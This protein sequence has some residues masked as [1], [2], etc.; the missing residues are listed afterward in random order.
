MFNRFLRIS[1]GVAA[2]AFATLA[3]SAVV[4]ATTPP[5]QDHAWTVALST[6]AGGSHPDI[7]S[8]LTM[9]TDG[10]GIGGPADECGAMVPA[11]PFF[12]HFAIKYFGVQQNGALPI[13]SRVA[14]VTMDVETN[15]GVMQGAGPN[16]GQPAKCGSVT[17]VAPTAFDLW[18]AT[19]TGTV[20]SMAPAGAG[21]GFSFDQLDDPTQANAGI[22]QGDGWPTGIREVPAVVPAFATL[23]GLPNAAI[24]SRGYGILSVVPGADQITVTVL[25]VAGGGNPGNLDPI[26]STVLFND[27]FAYGNALTNNN[28]TICTPFS[29]QLAQHGVSV[30]SAG[31]TS[32]NGTALTGPLDYSPLAPAG[33][34]DITLCSACTPPSREI[35]ALLSTVNDDDGDGVPDGED[36]CPTVDN[37]STNPRPHGDA[38][39]SFA[40]IGVACSAGQ[41]YDNVSAAAVAA[42]AACSTGGNAAVCTD[43]DGDGV[44]NAVDNCPFTAN[45]TQANVDV[46][47]R[48]DA[49]ETGPTITTKG[50]G[51][52]PY[53]PD[54]DDRC[55]APY[56]LG[57]ATSLSTTCLSFGSTDSPPGPSITMVDSSDDGFPDSCCPG[58]SFD[59]RNHKADA[60]GDGYSNADEGT[61]KDCPLTGVAWAANAVSMTDSRQAWVFNQFV[62]DVVT[63]GGSTAT[64]T[65][66]TGTV[67][68][69]S[70]WAPLGPAK[71]AYSISLG[72]CAATITLGTAET[73][74]C[75]DAGRHCGC[76]LVCFPLRNARGVPDL[77]D[78]GPEGCWVLVDT[79]TALKTTNLGKSD[80][81]LDGV[82]S[83]LDL[84]KAASWIG[85]PVGNNTDP[86]WEANM[87][88]DGSI[89]ILDLS[90]IAANFGRS[91]NLDCKVE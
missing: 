13:A 66:N 4:Q 62:G 29:M 17:H 44:L 60:N 52:A 37:T 75:L 3:S 91:V 48:G 8:A 21:G 59:P 31:S 82:V 53:A 87:D 26:E 14:Q 86:R 18:A 50:D 23:T 2:L 34:T 27:D 11:Q 35:D 54:F 7:T 46:D 63:M 55:N 83:I 88:G 47:G 24:I 73:H 80:I 20:V 74:S 81:D 38:Q 89:S 22:P 64:I 36:D 45:P 71:G 76:V 42:L 49:C 56:S 65:S 39:V 61:L 9:C 90:A 28:V 15:A 33:T 67:L 77:G 10:L 32:I 58:Y 30:A 43:I 19:K 68:S 70:A 1:I 25:T 84:A 5:G 41:G 12:D 16:A 51:I 79:T 57:G 69:F 85:Q 6:T 72:G 78:A 40:G